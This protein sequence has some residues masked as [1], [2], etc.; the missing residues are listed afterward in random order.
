MS[1]SS[2]TSHRSLHLVDLENLV[3]DPRATGPIVRATFDHYLD[4]AGW[5]PGDHVVVASNP[6]LV[7]EV[8]F[9]LPVACNVHTAIGEDGADLMLL[10]HAPPEWIAKRFGRLVVG[11]GDGI[12]A[13][14]ATHAHALGVIASSPTTSGSR[15]EHLPP[16]AHRRGADPPVLSPPT[17]REHR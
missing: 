6:A 5:Q 10:S 11:S 1:T 17:G 7:R 8:C 3:G 16:Q 4:V 13:A 2:I 15:H 12:F 9:D 14:R